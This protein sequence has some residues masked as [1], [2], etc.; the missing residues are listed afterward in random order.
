MASVA[1]SVTVIPYV[2][3]IPLTSLSTNAIYVVAPVILVSCHALRSILQTKIKNLSGLVFDDFNHNA[4]NNNK[5]S[6]NNAYA[7]DA[8]E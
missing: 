3:D 7:N 8:Y 5:N 6:N 2:T 1:Q 4:N